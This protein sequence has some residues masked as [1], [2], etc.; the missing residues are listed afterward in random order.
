MLISHY[1]GRYGANR[2]MVD[3]G[4]HLRDRG[5]EPIVIIPRN[6]S[7]EQDLRE[8]GIP[9]RVLLFKQWVTEI[10]NRRNFIRDSLVK[11]IN[12]I[13]DIRLAML[14]IK[15]QADLIHINSSCIRVG[16]LASRWLNIPLVWHI[17]EYLEQD[18]RLRF[19]NPKKALRTI[20][21]ADRVIAV[22]QD[23]ADKYQSTLGP[24][25][26][27]IHNGIRDKEQRPSN[28]F[29]HPE[30]RVLMVGVLDPC[31]GHLVAIRAIA[32]AKRD[33]GLK[34][35][36]TIIGEGS[37][38][39]YQELKSLAF[40]L[41][42][43]NEVRFL[44]YQRDLRAIKECSD[45]GLVCSSREAFGRVT[46]EAMSAGLLVLASRSGGTCEIIQHERTG[47]LFEPGDPM[48]LAH[49]LNWIHQNRATSKEIAVHGQ[50]HA[51]RNFNMDRVAEEIIKVYDEVKNG[52]A[53]DYLFEGPIV[54][55]SR[56]RRNMNHPGF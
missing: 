34:A 46:V 26:S 17:R 19:S 20:G 48:A 45:I 32:A 42:V 3:L 10:G 2:S 47:L 25:L 6:G 52:Q 53:S 24:K 50:N 23:L 35:L 38:E 8:E 27:V 21:S 41:G 4:V 5:I 49:R 56:P 16:S 30:L 55:G 18:Y 22:S 29:R 14:A 28:Q 1:A 9:Y 31:K 12:F 51:R 54:I 44:G 40:K 37:K 43:E 36:L 7:I 13:A 15:H 11:A 33:F 39:F